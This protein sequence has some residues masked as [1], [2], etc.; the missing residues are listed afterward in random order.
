MIEIE[1]LHGRAQRLD[2]LMQEKLGGK[3]RTLEKKF[4]RA[5]R[6]L[7]RRIQRAGRVIT[8]AQQVAGHPKLARLS[9]PRALEQAFTEVTAYLRTIDP[10][11]RRKGA[12]L[13]MLGGLVFNLLLLV[14]G[15]ILVLHWRGMF[16]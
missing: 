5:G 12:A 4:A 14:A 3:G 8:D 2:A 9:D 6:A 11:D 7:P 13:G 1:K 15:V 16:G 10:A